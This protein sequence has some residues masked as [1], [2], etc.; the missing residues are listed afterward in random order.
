MSFPSTPELTQTSQ[1]NATQNLANSKETRDR[2]IVDAAR[3]GLKAVENNNELYEWY[4]MEIK[5]LA[6]RAA[7]KVASLENQ[8]GNRSG[9]HF[10]ESFDS[11][12]G[13]LLTHVLVFRSV[14]IQE[15]LALQ[16]HNMLNTAKYPFYISS[17]W[18]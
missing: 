17:S 5:Q 18:T 7:E 10:G 2:R 9:L 14:L 4:I 12:M 3:Q 1:A 15:L 16:S 13:K 8:D 11:K 6:S